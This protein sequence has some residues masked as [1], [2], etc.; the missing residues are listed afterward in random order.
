MKS[1]NLITL[2]LI[3]LFAFSSVTSQTRDTWRSV[4]TNNLLV[5][6]NADPEKLRQV[7]AWLEF[8]HTAFARLVSRNVIDSSV[9]TTVVIFRDD[10]SFLPFK[11]LYQ[12]RP[13]NLAGFFQPGDDVNYIALSLDPN[14]RD[15]YSTAFHEYVHLHIKDNVPGA[16]LWLN[17]G[18]AELY[19]SLQFSGNDALLGA[20]LYQYIR[21][22]REQELLPLSTLFSIGTNSP[23]YNE[24]EKSGIFYGQSWALA[25]YLMLGDRNRPEQFKRFLQQVGRGEDSAKAIQDAFGMSLPMLEEDLRAYVRRGNLAPQ[26]IA[27]VDSPQAYASYTA[28]QRS[29]LTDSEA[30]YY[31]GD[32]LLHTG[33]NSDA[34]RYFKQAIASDPGFIPAHAALGQLYVQQRRY[35]DAKKYLQKAT[36]SPQS[37]L[38]H[39]FYAYVLGQ[40]GISATGLISEYSRQNAVV[41]REQLL[42]S[43]KLA[44][45]YAPAHYLLAVV[46]LITNEHLDEALE[47]AQKAHQLA[48]ANS[49]YS[50]LLDQ[51]K[52]QRSDATAARQPR[53]TLKSAMITEPVQAGTSRMLG[54]D[55]SGVAIN[56][57]RTVDSS[58]ALTTVDELL[59]KYLDALGG[60]T[61]INAVTSRV[62]KGT[63]DVVGVSRGGA[64]ETYTLAPN[65]ALSILQGPPT[66]TVKAGY[67]GRTG[68]IQTPDGVRTL[69]GPE[70]VSI[71][72]EADFNGVLKLKNHYAK[73]TLLGKSKIGYREVYVMELQPETGAADKLYLDAESYLPVRLNSSR[74]QQGVSVPLEIYFD[75]W[76]EVDGL[77]IPY[78]MTETFPRRTVILTVKEIR[79]NVPVDAKLF[80]SPSRN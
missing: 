12:G 41:M 74:V 68:W 79:N 6:G 35:A 29:S 1:K 28:M 64:F 17:E 44:P 45:D 42:Q 77:K 39:Y 75:D 67:N 46:N 24:Q 70:L 15:P 19:G 56:D 4:R 59:K 34:E 8:F 63:F 80:E 61:A 18:L 21:L 58:G 40:E 14:D 20:P 60:A 49:H 22:L 53:E 71:Q 57:G 48:P 2:L 73:V 10:A 50:D 31:L 5:I 33:R 69:K 66:I 43:I 62:I 76:R 38:V 11:P 9:P 25:H 13:A 52:L 78:V 51:I 16:P 54:G 30:N 55:T 26:R 7:A 65:K 3:V 36:S 47:L 37:Y 32:L 72:S 27:S 23:H